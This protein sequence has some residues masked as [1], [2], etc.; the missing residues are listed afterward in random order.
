MGKIFFVL[1]ATATSALSVS[2]LGFDVQWTPTGGFNIT[3]ATATE[4]AA[5]HVVVRTP[6]DR[7]L[8]DV[9][10]D[11]SVMEESSGNFY[12]RFDEGH[13][14]PFCPF[15]I[16]RNVTLDRGGRDDS[17]VLAGDLCVSEERSSS[18][19]RLR[20]WECVSFR[21]VL[22]SISDAAV[23]GSSEKDHNKWPIVRWQIQLSPTN[24]SDHLRWNQSGL[25]WIAIRGKPTAAKLTLNLASDADEHVFGAGTQFTHF[26]LKGHR[27]PILSSEQGVGRGMQPLTTLLERTSPHAAGTSFTTYTAT[28]LFLTSAANGLFLNSSAY[29]VLDFTE[30]NETTIE[31]SET[32]EET[33][34]CTAADGGPCTLLSLELFTFTHTPLRDD[35]DSHTAT[36]ASLVHTATHFTGRQ[37]VLP[38][39]ISAGV[40]VGY[41]GGTQRAE[42][43][44]DFLL[45]RGVPLVGL[46][47]QDWTGVRETDFGIRLWWSWDVDRHHYP[48]WE[49][50]L[51]R[52]MDKKVRVWTYSNPYLSTGVGDDPRMK[53]RRDLFAEAA[54]AGVLVM[55]ESGLPYVQYSVDPAFRFGTVDLTNQTGRHFFVDLIRCHMLHLPEFCPSDDTVNSTCRSETGRP[56][57]VAGWMADFSE[58]LPFD[59]ALASGRGR[60]IHNAFPQLWASVNHEA[61]QETPY[62]LSD[63]GRETGEEVIFFMRAGGVQG[64]RYT[65]LFWLGDQLTSW[66]EHDGIRSALIGHLTAGLSGWS[67][68]HSDVGGYTMLDAPSPNGGGGGDVYVRSK[69]LLLRWMEMNAFTDA[70]LRTHQGNRP[71]DAWQVWTDGESLEHLKKFATVHRLLA[72]YK[73]A[74]MRQ[75]HAY[76]LPLVRHTLFHMPLNEETLSLPGWSEL[77]GQCLVGEDLLVVPVLTQGAKTVTAYFPPPWPSPIPLQQP[78]TGQPTST[79]SLRRRQE[80][81]SSFHPDT[82]GCK[83]QPDGW[84]HLWSG[85]VY[86][87]G[88]WQADIPAPIGQPAVFVRCGWV[89]M[90]GLLGG[91]RDAGYL[92]VS[93]RTDGDSYYEQHI[94]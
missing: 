64:P 20:G 9:S 17:A 46:W 74:L 54:G 19:Q 81:A 82:R 14:D 42:E 24:A 41:W 50:M 43:M 15:E 91:L 2:I 70:V 65:P 88:G 30:P 44:A 51:K 60:D 84:V 94:S 10:A 40:I 12:E 13:A 39:W 73:Q 28:P 55:N 22:S 59:A 61:L 31:V 36:L 47:L 53:G 7:F 23:R 34:E 93:V 85:R 48:G 57:P 71:E 75:A 25:S 27:V 92:T 1:V 80:E 90:D 68:T 6:P 26:D 69:E 49:C 21:V 86:S 5:P 33:F 79:P 78:A 45:E 67:L 76:G 72:P 52:L 16:P 89:Y 62:A 11:P 66:D 58:Y 37:R 35:G 63:D 29:C 4:D 87:A 3:T 77:L 38:S 32:L 56:V 83:S 18:C 8:F